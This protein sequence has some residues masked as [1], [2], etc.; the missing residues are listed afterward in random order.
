LI[1]RLAKSTAVHTV[2]AFLLMGGWA[3]YANYTHGTRDASQAAV[4]QGLLSGGI[5][6]TLKK[7]LDWLSARFP[8]IWGLIAPPLIACSVSFCV[9]TGS[10]WLAGTPEILATIAVPF[11][12]AFLY[13]WGYSFA[14][15]RAKPAQPKKGSEIWSDPETGDR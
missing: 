7:A 9:L 4:V 12:V 14:L 10:H 3:F 6:F 1:A 2:S 15:W 8:G 5:T 11:S 13:A